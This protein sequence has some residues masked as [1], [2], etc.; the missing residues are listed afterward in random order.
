MALAEGTGLG[1]SIV[2]EIVARHDGRVEIEE[3]L[4]SGTLFRVCLPVLV[5]DNAGAE[6][7]QVMIAS[8]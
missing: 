5:E 4:P 1:L 7:V 2:A 8:G 3:R 6:D